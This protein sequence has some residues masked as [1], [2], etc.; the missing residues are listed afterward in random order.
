MMNIFTETTMTSPHGYEIPMLS[1][2]GADTKEILLCLHGFAGSKRSSVIAAVAEALKG[3]G[4][5][6]VTFDWPAHGESSAPGAA[7]TVENCLEDLTAV[8][9]SLRAHGLPVS[10]FATSFG[11]YLATLWRHE[12]PSAFR[13]LILRSPALKMNEVFDRIL[14]DEEKTALLNG[15]TITVERGRPMTLDRA[16]SDGLARHDAFSPSAPSPDSI[17]I[18]QGDRDEVVL[19]QDTAA[20][21]EKNGICIEWFRG[22]DHYYKRDGDRDRIAQTARAFLL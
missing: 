13:K 21:A 16:F 22:S 17:L 20:Y 6:V 4:I 19:P 18:L 5:G 9:A 11:G 15:G 3:D 14:T 10:C 8:Y 1:A 12:H 7:L 2:A